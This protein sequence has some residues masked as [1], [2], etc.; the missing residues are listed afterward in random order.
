MAKDEAD[1][2]SEE[3]EYQRDEALWRARAP[4]RLQ[5]RGVC[6]FC[7]EPCSG[8]F[9]DK[10]CQRDY[11]REQQVRNKQHGRASAKGKDEWN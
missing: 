6:Y 2:A 9:C 3:E 4:Q 1:R 8:R 7:D 10:N 11:E 5:V